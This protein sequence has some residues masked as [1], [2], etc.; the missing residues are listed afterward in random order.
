MMRFWAFTCLFLTFTTPTVSAQVIECP[1]ALPI[2]QL[3]KEQTIKLAER[4]L[5]RF[6]AALGLHGLNVIDEAAIADSYS[7]H[8][9]QL[10]TKLTYLSLQC[11]MVLLDSTMTAGARS[12]AVRRVFLD[13][14]LQPP[15]GDAVSLAAYV[16]NV[17]ANGKPSDDTINDPAIARIEL[18]LLR[19]ARHQWA[20]DWFLEAPARVI[21]TPPA[22][23]SV[24]IASPRFEDDGWQTLRT[25]Q[26]RW[27]DIHFE[28]DGPF[29]LDE[30]HYAIVAGR[31]LSEES[32][33]QLLKQVKEMGLPQ[34]SFTWRAPAKV[35]GNS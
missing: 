7:D 23:F 26:E 35:D 19:S 4:L 18:T 12:E 33:N 20:E 32:A 21:G 6:T 28:L 27:P 13:Y 16:N 15:D 17:A 11:Q 8:P 25:Y 24:I 22:R 29:D 34:D 2:A 30:P 3:K 1:G 9:E 14:V 10:L 5:G 31:G